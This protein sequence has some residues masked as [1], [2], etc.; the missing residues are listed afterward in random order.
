MTR[1]GSTLVCF[2]EPGYFPSFDMLPHP[3]PFNLYDPWGVQK[4][5]S[6][7]ELERGRLVEINNGRL[8][9]LGLFGFL[10]E[11]K[12]PGAVPF[13]KGVVQP[14]DGEVMAP[15][16]KNIFSYADMASTF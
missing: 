8:A 14:Y 12:E 15:F 16:L 5:K 3:V 13:L 10:S 6:A 9:M 7:E 1:F 2:A 11:S 4:G